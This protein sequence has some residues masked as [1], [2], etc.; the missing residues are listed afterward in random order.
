MRFN[1]AGDEAV[2]RPSLFMLVYVQPSFAPR[3][4]GL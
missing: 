4:Q 2:G 3:L 1:A